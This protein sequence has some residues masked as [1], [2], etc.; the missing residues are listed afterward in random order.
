MVTWFTP[1][2]LGAS[3]PGGQSSGLFCSYLSLCP[4]GP[5]LS[6][7]GRGVVWSAP[8]CPS[9]P[10][11]EGQVHS[12][13]SK[14]EPQSGLDSGESD[15]LNSTE[16]KLSSECDILGGAKLRV[17]SEAH[18]LFPHKVSPEYVS[19]NF[20][21]LLLRFYKHSCVNVCTWVYLASACLEC[22]VVIRK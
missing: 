22:S 12:R 8:I 16:G 14:C 19:S 11:L 13:D 1:L 2:S 5:S 9:T 21:I 10:I 6:L 17:C 4:W 3:V 7:E 15:I 20:H 18:V